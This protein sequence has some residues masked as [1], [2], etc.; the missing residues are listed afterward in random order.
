MLPKNEVDRCEEFA[1][2]LLT[3]LRKA[4]AGQHFDFSARPLGL[5]RSTE[6]S[7]WGWVSLL[8][9]GSDVL[10]LEIWIG[11]YEDEDNNR[12]WFGLYLPSTSLEKEFIGALSAKKWFR[13]KMP[14]VR[15]PIYEVGPFLGIYEDVGERREA[16][17]RRC[18]EFSDAVSL[19]LAN[20]TE[21]TEAGM[22]VERQQRLGKIA[23]RKGQR[24]FAEM[25]RLKYGRKCAVTGC[26]VGE[27]LEAAHIRVG[28]GIDF[29]DSANGILLRADIH[30][31]FDRCLITLSE[32]GRHIEVSRKLMTDRT[33]R[34]LHKRP[35]RRPSF[36]SAPSSRNIGHHRTRFRRANKGILEAVLSRGEA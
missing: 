35:V 7:N 33:Y 24:Q 21:A 22:E 29:N 23:Q 11:R 2:T 17:L 26:S 27:V 14:D 3:R 25:I 20:R 36:G 15:H 10:D 28:K 30:A 31:L 16:Y 1:V 13:G 8:E 12:L 4:K 5:K 6:N 32:D 19:T 34:S 9:N 18:I